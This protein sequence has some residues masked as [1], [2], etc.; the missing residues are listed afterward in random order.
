MKARLPKKNG[1]D[2]N[3]LYCKDFSK[4]KQNILISVNALPICPS[5]VTVSCH[6]GTRSVKVQ[7]L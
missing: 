6:T 4:L 7:V 2:D 5:E 1:Q 3:E